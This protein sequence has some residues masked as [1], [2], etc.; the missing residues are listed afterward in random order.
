VSLDQLARKAT[1]MGDD[2]VGYLVNYK[3]ETLYVHPVSRG[4]GAYTTLLADGEELVGEIDVTSRFKLALSMFHVCERNDYSSF[5]LTKLK[6]HRTHGWQRDGEVK[7]NGFALSR[8]GEFAQLLSMLDFTE[9]T[10]SRISLSDLNFQNLG[11]ILRSDKGSALLKQISEEPDLS[12]DIFA[13][14]H[15][16]RELETFRRLLEEFDTFADGY[17]QHHR[18]KKTGEEDIW[19][20]F[21]ERNPWI[22]GHGL[23]YVF[24]DKEG[25]KLEAVTTGAAHGNAGNRVDALM[26]TRAAISQYVL[27][28]IKKASTDLLRKNPYRSGCWTVSSEVSDAVSQIQ[29]TVFDF[30]S[31][32]TPKVQTRTEDGYLTG[33]EIFRVRP[34]SYLIIGNLTKMKDS[35]ERFTCFQL[36]RGSLTAPEILTYDELY[37]RAQCIVETLGAKRP[38]PRENK[39]VREIPAVDSPF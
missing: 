11:A 22:F 17:V 32:Q 18:V 23:N 4:T 19:Q 21:F 29:K 35:D 37:E 39:D 25:K 6:F 12:E 2:D 31:N 16:K 13:L 20:H 34:K 26:R 5:K 7:I 8:L 9:V 24:L 10:K 38:V 28:E 33:D 15:K 14:A 1:N 36:F 30:T 27:I 3:P